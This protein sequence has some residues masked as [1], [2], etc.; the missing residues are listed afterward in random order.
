MIQGLDEGILSMKVGGL[1]RLYIPGPVSSVDLT[2]LFFRSSSLTIL[3]M[4]ADK[5]AIWKRRA[6]CSERLGHGRDGFVFLDYKQLAFPKGLTSAPGRPRVPPSSPVVFDVNLLYIPGLDDEWKHS[7]AT[8]IFFCTLQEQ[9]TVHSPR[10]QF[11]CKY[12]CSVF[13]I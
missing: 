11:M 1:R 8:V 2:L 13:S 6:S 10:L 4:K 3:K 7:A 12:L 9:L 5:V